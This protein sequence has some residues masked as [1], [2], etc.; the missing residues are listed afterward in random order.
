MINR[1]TAD[2]VWSWHPCP[3][4]P[5]ARIDAI[6]GVDGLTPLRVCDLSDVSAEDKLWTLLR[7]EVL[8]AATLRLLAYTWAEGRYAQGFAT[9]EELTA[10]RDAARDAAWAAARDAAWA[11]ARTA[12]ADAARAAG[13]NAAWRAARGGARETAATTAWQTAATTAWQAAEAA[14]W[15]AQLADVREILAEA[16]HD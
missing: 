5:R 11:A 1:L 2:L 4:Y 12:A 15:E 6:Y 10:A 7:E 3:R 9:A 16:E 13:R 14:A 8:P